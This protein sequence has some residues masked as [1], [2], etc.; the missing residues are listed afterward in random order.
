M[1]ISLNISTTYNR[2]EYKNT[3]FSIFSGKWNAKFSTFEC[4]RLKAK[5][6]YCD[7][8]SL[9]D[10]N[11]Y[12]LWVL[13]LNLGY[14]GH[15]FRRAI[16]DWIRDIKKAKID[17]HQLNLIRNNDSDKHSLDIA[18]L[19]RRQMQALLLLYRLYDA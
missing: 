3:F 1:H 15:I 2:Y 14:I 13:K 9:C 17:F 11:L 10:W 12:I 18:L 8:L 19:A 5:I 4:K 16:N 7:S 6:E